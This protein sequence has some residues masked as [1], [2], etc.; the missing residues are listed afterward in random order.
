MAEWKDVEK[1]LI[2]MEVGPPLYFSVM[3][4]KLQ[5]TYN[6]LVQARDANSL[7]AHDDYRL[8][9]DLTVPKNQQ[10]EVDEHTRLDCW[11]IK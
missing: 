2:N 7:Q 4:E 3:D 1:W 5:N 10:S 9:S 11:I 6:A 8:V